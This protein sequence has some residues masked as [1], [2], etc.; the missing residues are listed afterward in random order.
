MLC[1][2]SQ[3]PRNL[4]NINPELSSL[5]VR[6]IINEIQLFI[7]RPHQLCRQTCILQ[8]GRLRE[9]PQRKWYKMLAKLSLCSSLVESSLHRLARSSHSFQHGLQARSRYRRLRRHRQCCKLQKGGLSRRDKYCD[10]RSC[11][12]IS[13]I[14]QNLSDNVLNS[15]A[16]S[17]PSATICKRISS[18]VNV[19]R[20]STSPSA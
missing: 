5:G 7:G 20:T 1:P 13:S 2:C 19:V 6:C 9:K 17:S 12:C 14:L 3:W 10:K 8:D 15:A 4:Q 11:Q 16:C 18:M